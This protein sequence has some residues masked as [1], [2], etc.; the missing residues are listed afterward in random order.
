MFIVQ[1]EHPYQNASLVLFLTF[2][3]FATVVWKRAGLLKH[4]FILSGR[5]S[6]LNMPVE[7]GPRI[8][9]NKVVGMV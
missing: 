8:S 2:D 6:L 5:D 7:S 1:G 3:L 9:T 4:W